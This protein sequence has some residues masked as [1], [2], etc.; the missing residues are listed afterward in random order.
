[1]TVGAIRWLVQQDSNVS[2]E[3]E[4][5]R[6]AQGGVAVKSAHVSLWLILPE[7]PFRVRWDMLV[8]LLSAFTLVWVPLCPILELPHTGE[9]LCPLDRLC[10][11]HATSTR[12][13]LRAARARRQGL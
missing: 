8:L 3:I 6:R 11:E 9:D 10:C 1:M 2:S 5:I 13:H 7:A 4:A 12:A